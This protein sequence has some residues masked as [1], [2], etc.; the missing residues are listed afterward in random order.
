MDNMTINFAPRAGPGQSRKIVDNVENVD[1]WRKTHTS[2]RSISTK[3]MGLRDV[4]K[5]G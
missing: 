1:K 3:E 4:D 5:C 2:R